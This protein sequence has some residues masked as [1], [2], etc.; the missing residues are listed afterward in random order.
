[1]QSPLFLVLL[2][3]LKVILSLKWLLVGAIQLVLK[4]IGFFDEFT[5][6]LVEIL[7]ALGVVERLRI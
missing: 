7:L 1:M 5:V 6:L 2:Q 4:G 3:I